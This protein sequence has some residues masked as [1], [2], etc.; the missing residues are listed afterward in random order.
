MFELSRYILILLCYICAFGV[1]LSLIIHY[2]SDF[3]PNKYVWMCSKILTVKKIVDN[4]NSN[5]VFYKFINKNQK[6]YKYNYSTILNNSK[7][8]NECKEGYKKCGILDTYNNS[9][10]LSQS[11]D[12]PI[13]KMQHDSISKSS[14]YLNNDYQHYSSDYKDT[15][16]Y[17]KRGVQESDIIVSWKISDSQPKYIDKYNFI[18]DLETFSKVFDFFDKKEEE[19]EDD[20]YDDNQSNDNYNNEDLV[21]I[22]SSSMAEAGK[23]FAE[24]LARNGSKYIRINNFLKYV[25]NKFNEESNIDYNYINIGKNNY[26]KNYIGFE[27]EEDINK[28]ERIDF[29]LY[30]ERYPNFS[31]LVCSFVYGAFFFVCIIIFIIEIILN[32]RGHSITNERVKKIEII[33]FLIYC[34]SFLLFFI[35]SLVIYATVYNKESFDLA[36]SIKADKF[37]EDFLKEFYEPFENPKI[38]ITTLVFLSISTIIFISA[39]IIEPCYEC[40]KK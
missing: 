15:Y 22:I 39:W 36:K 19:D 40:I 12:C 2:Y 14:E 17:Y 27:S 28:F 24:D 23:D 6:L 16:L 7:N 34:A 3:S 33:S 25:E 38:L 9:F 21:D 18:L 13:N 29:N 31:F 35:Y 20:D 37:I 4:N 10:C 32:I 8:K 5:K 30:K 11:S 26:V 1:M